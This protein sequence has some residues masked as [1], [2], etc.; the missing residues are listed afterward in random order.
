V[1]AF[2][3]LLRAVNVGGRGT[4]AMRDLCETAERLGFGAPRTLLQSG[5][6][7][8][9]SDAKPDDLKQRLETA[10]RADHGLE[11]TVLVRSAE[12][13]AAI[14]AA[15]P[16]PD[17]AGNDPAHLLVMPLRAPPSAQA[18]ADLRQAIAG[19]E[20]VELRGGTAYVH[21]PDGIGRS[22]LTASLIE[23]RLGT[24]GTA[25]NWNT[26]KRIEAALAG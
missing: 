25:R 1:P 3:A 5:N 26:V 9:T 21:Y 14:V 16:Y 15:C 10:V 11:T 24:T 6:L 23:R 7:V 22:K 19:R 8:F 17:I 20:R 2:V 13:W 4:V 12:E 18:E